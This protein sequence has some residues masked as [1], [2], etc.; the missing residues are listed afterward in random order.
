MFTEEEVWR[1]LSHVEW[2]RDLASAE[3]ELGEAK[4]VQKVK[5]IQVRI[6]QIKHY[7]EVCNP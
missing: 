3:R 2:L 4:S 6:R 7:I 1:G 5:S